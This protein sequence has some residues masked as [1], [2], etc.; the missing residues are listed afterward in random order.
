MKVLTSVPWDKVDIEVML[1][2]LHLAGKVFPGTRED[3]HSFLDEKGYE[4]K[5]T[6]GKL[7]ILSNIWIYN[8]VVGV[9]DIFIR[10]DLAQGKYN[11]DREMAAEFDTYSYTSCYSHG[12]KDEL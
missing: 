2:E 4:Y 3:V 8:H 12:N 10:K 6:V 7:N 5:G 9:D 1:V 11:F